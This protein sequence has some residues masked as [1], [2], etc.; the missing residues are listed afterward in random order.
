MPKIYVQQ[1]LINMKKLLLFP[2]VLFTLIASAQVEHVN[3]E[4][5]IPFDQD[6]YFEDFSLSGSAYVFQ[7]DVINHKLGT[8]HFNFKWWSDIYVTV[9]ATG[10]VIKINEF[11]FENGTRRTDENG[12]ITVSFHQRIKS[13]KD[14]SGFSINLVLFQTGIYVPGEGWYWDDPDIKLNK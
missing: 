10:E 3:T 9:K 7:K 12:V 4:I 6:P 14:P 8:V 2:L 11:Y 1:T 13:Q 5:V